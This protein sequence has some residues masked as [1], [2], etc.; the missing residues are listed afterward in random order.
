[1]PIPVILNP[2]ARSTKAAV[3][4]MPLRRL[5]P[6]PE[7]H[8]TRA[9]ATRPSLL[10]NWTEGHELIV[11]AGGDGTM[12]EVLQGVCRANARRKPGERHTALG[13]LPLG[14]MNVFSVELKLPGRDI[15][16]CWREDH[17]RPAPGGRPVDG[18]R[19][20]LRA[21]RRGGTRCAD[22]AGDFVGAEEKVWPAELC[23]ERGKR[24]D[25]PTPT[26][27]HADRGQSAAAGHGGAHGQWQALRRAVP[28]VPRRI[29]H[30]WEARFDRLPRPGRAWNSCNCCAACCSTATK[31]ASTSTTSRPASSP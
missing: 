22:R 1:M 31:S 5:S 8:L 4:S 28:A 13:V 17:L 30:G 25:A 23:H 2:A 16:G 21:A 11:S 19:H 6:A 14:T 27:Q 7:L 20:V 9:P 12:N 29:K 18:E 26:L 24:A 15:E 10:K 3:S